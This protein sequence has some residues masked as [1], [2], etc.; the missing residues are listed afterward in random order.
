VSLQVAVGALTF[1]GQFR[2]AATGSAGFAVR[3]GIVLEETLA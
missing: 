1:S 2:C 3:R